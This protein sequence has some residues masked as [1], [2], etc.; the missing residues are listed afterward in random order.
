MTFRNRRQMNCKIKQNL[1]KKRNDFVLSNA[2]RRHRIIGLQKSSLCF[3]SLNEE[4][5]ERREPRSKRKEKKKSKIKLKLK[6]LVC[7]LLSSF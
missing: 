7:F 4:A 5:K 1:K 3:H 6:N 2:N